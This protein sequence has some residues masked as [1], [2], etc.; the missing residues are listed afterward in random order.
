MSM[1]VYKPSENTRYTVE[2]FGVLLMDIATGQRR[3]LTFPQAAIW[4]LIVQ[5]RPLN[6][7][8][9]MMTHIAVL[10][11]THA[12][13]LIQDLLNELVEAGLILR[14]DQHG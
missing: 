4:D 8:V 5:N 13:A 10:S 11:A 14:K 6:Q 3:Y 7:M 9:E 2:T 12:K 1:V